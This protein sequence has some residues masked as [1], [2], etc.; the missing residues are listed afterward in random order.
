LETST[1][2]AREGGQDKYRFENA[3]RAR[4]ADTSSYERG[5]KEGKLRFVLE[6][7]EEEAVNRE[8]LGFKLDA[9]KDKVFACIAVAKVMNHE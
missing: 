9:K 1:D 4:K 2:S 3:S 5:G 6:A 7:K 8:K